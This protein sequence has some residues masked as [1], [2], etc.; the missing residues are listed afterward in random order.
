MSEGLTTAR[1]PTAPRFAP[2]LLLL[3]LLLL[4][5]AACPCS[6]PAASEDHSD[7]CT[8]SVLIEAEPEGAAFAAAA[9]TAAT[10]S[11]ADITGCT[12]GSWY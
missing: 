6:T 4:P 7:A 10:A 8:P 3:L 1:A 12:T 5:E 11:K 9:A 2:P